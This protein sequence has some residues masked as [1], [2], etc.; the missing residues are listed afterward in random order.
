MPEGPEVRITADGLD[1]ITRYNNIHSIEVTEKSRYHR[2]GITHLYDV[3]YPLLVNEV[4]SR[5]KKIIFNCL[6]YNGYSVTLVSALGMEGKWRT[7]DGKHAGIRL[8]LNDGVI[9]YFHDTRHFG[10]FDICMSNDEYHFV[11]KSVGPDLMRDNISYDDYYSVIKRKRLGNKDVYCF[12]MDQSYFSGI[13]N[14]LAAE[15]LYASQILPDRTLGSLSNDEVYRLYW[16]SLELI[17]SSY[18]SGGMTISTYFDLDDKPGSFTCKCY[19]RRYDP[20][21]REIVK[22]T[23]SNGRTSWYCP[24]YQF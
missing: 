4:T 22:R 8:Y 18:D 24:D 6:D 2:E 11:M 3:T 13:G 9:V 15:A 1:R 16:N 23:F 7:Y 14:Y 10:T 20:E 12:L 17:Q 19:G 5:G 21:G